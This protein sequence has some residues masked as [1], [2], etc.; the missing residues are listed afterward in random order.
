MKEKDRMKILAGSGMLSEVRVK[1]KKKELEAIE[2]IDKYDYLQKSFKYIILNNNSNDNPYHNLNH[3]LTV[4]KYTYQGALE[5]NVT[6][7][8]LR[9]LLIA[10]IF[11]DTNHTAGKQK[12][13]VN[14]K[15]SKKL[16]KRFVESEGIDAELENIDKILDA[17][18]YPYEIESRDLSVSQSIIRDA[19]LMQ[20]YE[21]N[22]IHQNI[23][24]LSSEIGIDFLDFVEPQKKFLNSAEFNTDWGRRMKKDKWKDVMNQYEM[25][26]RACSVELKS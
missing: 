1:E 25:F 12:D 24:G 22:W 8:A 20:V 19:D 5:E 15:N 13:D 16:I 9:E 26:E 17:T 11:H 18:Q 7:K 2:I 4:L 10:A 6:G 21:Y 14:I 3:L 23:L